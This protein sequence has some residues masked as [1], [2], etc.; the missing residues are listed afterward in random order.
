MRLDRKS[1]AVAVTA[2]VTAFAV[3]SVALAANTPAKGK[4]VKTMGGG[5]MMTVNTG[6]KLTVLEPK[7]GAVITGNAVD[8]RIAV[9]NFRLDAGLA[10][11]PN[12]PGVG[13]Y[14]IM[15]D[16]SLINMFGA[17]TASVS[18]QNVAP[19]KHTL[20]FVPAANDHAEDMKAA[21]S[22]TF[23]YK[24]TAPLPQVGPAT[25]PGKPSVRI[26][27]PKNGATVSGGF[28][29]VVAVKNFRLSEPLYGKADV[30]GYGHW[31]VNLDSTTMGPMGMATM[32]G[33]SGTPRFHVSLEGVKPGK[34]RFWAILEDNTH[35][36]TI[37]VMTS[38]AV[39]VK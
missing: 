18:L 38:V 24:P 31:H 39:T 30:A 13:H 6:A 34:H 21:R 1:V 26:V 5:A 37:G 8:T 23:V 15:L 20:M 22:V 36:P 10:G 12:R 17:D 25:F 16:G 7:N 3:V 35:A 19:G 14:H 9:A 11:T 2:A 4:G 28:D 27:S 29:M 33:M 32:M